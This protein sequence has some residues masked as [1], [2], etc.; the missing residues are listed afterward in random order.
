MK[1]GAWNLKFGTKVDHKR[2]YK[3]AVNIVCMPSTN[4]V[5]MRNFE[6]ISENSAKNT[7]I[8]IKLFQNFL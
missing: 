3:H 8:S 7:Y 4:M 6:T 5:A 1:I 2:T